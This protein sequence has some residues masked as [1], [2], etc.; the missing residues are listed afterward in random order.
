MVAG[1]AAISQSANTTTIN[2]SS[3]RA[4]I[5][6]QSFDVGAQQSVQFRQPDANA[7][8]LNR[9]V[10]PDPSQIAGH[11]DANGQVILVNQDGITFYRGAQVNAAGLVASA[12]GMSN[13]DFMAG[14]M[15]F[16]QPA[17]PG[18]ARRQ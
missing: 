13:Q 16:D 10:G 4:A 7:V 17:H 1:A 5:N 8:A 3:Q 6:W 18:A 9:V 11:I 2:Q 14:R 12:V 15:A